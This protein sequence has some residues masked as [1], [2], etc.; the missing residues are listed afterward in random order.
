MKVAF[1]PQAKDDLIEIGVYIAQDNPKR[2]LSFISEL[3]AACD[4]LGQSADI[5]RARPE[6]GQDIRAWPHGR[7][8]IFYRKLVAKEIR[9]ERIL[10]SS[11]DIDGEDF[12]VLHP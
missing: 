3:E 8:L 4:L 11:R 10:H 6:L 7:Y 1:A 9:I 2:A 12:T 5:G